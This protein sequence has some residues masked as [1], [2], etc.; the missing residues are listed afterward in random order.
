MVNI[1]RNN[2]RGRRYEIGNQKYRTEA[3]KTYR[4]ENE[5]P[6]VK[7]LRLITKKLNKF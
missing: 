5:P 2:F 3:H 7:D 1:F 4:S 6:R